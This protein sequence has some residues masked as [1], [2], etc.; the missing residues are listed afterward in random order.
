[1]PLQVGHQA[2][3]S[4]QGQ[5]WKGSHGGRTPTNLQIYL[6]TE[7][8]QEKN[9]GSVSGQR[10]EC[11]VKVV[12][13]SKNTQFMHFLNIFMWESTKTLK[14]CA[15][16]S[17]VG[18]SRVRT[19]LPKSG[20][21]QTPYHLDPPWQG[22]GQVGTTPHHQRHRSLGRDDCT[23]LNGNFWPVMRSYTQ[24]YRYALSTTCSTN[25][26]HPLGKTSEI[27]RRV[28][29]F[30]RWGNETGMDMLLK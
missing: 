30:V 24:M 17:K 13:K 25:D 1:M 12:G 27:F 26:H 14:K 19:P 6:E 5:G 2:L 22:G 8:G 11:Q 15:I 4:G 16:C 7:E 18:Q 20:G 29:S 28:S 21:G 23:E 3:P 10:A 9:L